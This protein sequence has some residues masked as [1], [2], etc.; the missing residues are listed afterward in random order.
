VFQVGD[1]VLLKLQPYAQSSLVNRPFPKLS[2]KFFDPYKVTEHISSATYRLELPAG[3]Q[4]NLVFHVSQLK[5]FTSNYAPVYSDLPVL[6][7]FSQEQL[8]PEAILERKLVKKGNAATPQVRIKWTCLPDL[9]ST[10][11]DWYELVSKF[12]VV[13]SWGQDNVSAGGAVTT[14][15]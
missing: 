10:W 1:Q 9:A 14:M 7:D 8:M 3:S 6:V 12:P 4:I 15:E 13:L 2:Y 5:P 11:K